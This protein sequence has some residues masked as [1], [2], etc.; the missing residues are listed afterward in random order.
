M[1]TRP[2]YPRHASTGLPVE[3]RRRALGIL[4]PDGPPP[5]VDW[6][7]PA[8]GIP[9]HARAE[10]C[11]SGVGHA[12]DHPGQASRASFRGRRRALV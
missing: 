3:Q 10:S 6:A 2:P 12:T 7:W 11:A 4:D 1:R 8:I 5:P 9:A